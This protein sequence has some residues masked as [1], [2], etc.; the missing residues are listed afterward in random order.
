[1]RKILNRLMAL[2]AAA[3]FMAGL[4]AMV[5]AAT[6]SYY[7]SS[8]FSQSGAY[9]SGAGGSYDP[10]P[11]ADWDTTH[12]QSDQNAIISNPYVQT[13]GS[14]AGDVTSNDSD[15]V[16]HVDGSVSGM[17]D[18]LTGH[19]EA[20][21]GTSTVQA[22]VTTGIYFQLDPEAG[23]NIGDPVRIDFYWMGDLGTSTGTSAHIDG[24]FAGDTIAITLN[25]YPAP[26]SFD[27]AKAVWTQQGNS[28]ADGAGDDFWDDEGFFMAAIGD[29]IGIHMGAETDLNLDGSG[30]A[31]SEASQT[32]EMTA[33]PVPIPGA[34]WLLGSGLLGLF[35]VR[36][37]R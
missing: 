22:A 27:P 30:F 20:Y 9:A 29:V 37:S 35:A 19:M 34:V 14:S 5:S 32:L 33:S 25:D 13:E 6:F 11:N 18:D 8:L 26:T 7:A 15:L 1:M 24:G 3:V 31:W 10:G 21:G 16:I 17:S 36:R 12:V 4:P 28:A 23:E 2:A